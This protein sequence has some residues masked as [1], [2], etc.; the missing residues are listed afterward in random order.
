MVGLRVALTTTM[1]TKRKSN[2]FMPGMPMTLHVAP[3]TD[4]EATSP[5]TE[6]GFIQKITWDESYGFKTPAPAEPDE[7]LKPTPVELPAR[8]YSLLTF[9]AGLL[10]A[11]TVL[12]FLRR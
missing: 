7:Q 6:G 1:W 2:G 10:A 11:L 4:K 12:T 8:V 3:P 5:A 9:I